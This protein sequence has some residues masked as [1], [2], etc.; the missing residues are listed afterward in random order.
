MDCQR[1]RHAVPRAEAGPSEA[2]TFNLSVGPGGGEDGICSP[3]QRDIQVVA[4]DD[5]L[6]LATCSGSV[7][8]AGTYDTRSG[9]GP[10][11]VVAVAWFPGESSSLPQAAPTMPSTTS[12]PTARAAVRRIGPGFA[13]MPGVTGQRHRRVPFW[14]GVDATNE[15]RHPEVSSVTSPVS[16]DRK[17][18]APRPLGCHS[19][20]T[21]VGKVTRRGER[22]AEDEAAAEGHTSPRSSGTRGRV[23]RSIGRSDLEN[24][25]DR[26]GKRCARYSLY[27]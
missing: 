15:G 21:T 14:S 24:H 16:T 19:A 25:H 4:L 5:P 17:Q 1:E 9:V 26:E 13:S 2:R 18:P 20:A 10:E 11:A 7:V 6:G 22:L 27:E 12:T 8:V 3:R 23:E